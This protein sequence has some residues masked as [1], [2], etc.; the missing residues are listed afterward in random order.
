MTAGRGWLSRH[1]MVDECE[2]RKGTESV[3]KQG[4]G[5]EGIEKSRVSKGIRKQKTE[6]NRTTTKRK[7]GG[8]WWLWVELL[9]SKSSRK[10]VKGGEKE[11]S[12]LREVACVRFACGRIEATTTT[13]A[14]GE[15][16]KKKGQKSSFP[17]ASRPRALVLDSRTLAAQ[18]RAPQVALGQMGTPAALH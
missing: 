17:A 13:P 6:K 11:E 10:E 9:I 1:T 15:R 16:A 18:K 14:R 5:R 2:E 7:M 12:R 3:E 8:N 4:Q